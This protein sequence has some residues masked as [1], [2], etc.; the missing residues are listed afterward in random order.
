MTMGLL[1]GLFGG[2]REPP[3]LDGSDPV[4][5]RLERNRAVLEDFARRVTDKLEILPGE[6]GTYVFVGKPPKTFGIVW[7]HDGVESNFKLL[8]KERGLS[9]AQVQI[10]SDEL[11]DAYARSEKE[12]RY[13]YD[14]AG[15]RVVVTP[16]AS[17]QRDVAQIIGKVTS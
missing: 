2:Q 9:A 12:P 1:G 6:R 15:R 5:P 3:A 11:R 10:L 17:L 4:V 14:L 13:S 7:F 8:M 16:S